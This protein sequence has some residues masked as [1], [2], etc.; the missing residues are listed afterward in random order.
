[1][2]VILSSLLLLSAT[3]Y[4]EPLVVGQGDNSFVIVDHAG[5]FCND[6]RALIKAVNGRLTV[7]CERSPDV[8][9]TISSGVVVNGVTVYG[10]A[11]EYIA[12]LSASKK[13]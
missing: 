13:P 1:M 5:I 4:A 2:R 8:A 9:I 6:N 3:A 10:D 12:T 7:W 11:L